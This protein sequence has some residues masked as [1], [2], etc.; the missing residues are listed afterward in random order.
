LARKANYNFAVDKAKTI[1]SSTRLNIIRADD[2][3]ELMAVR[4]FEKYA[5]QNVSFT[6]CVSFAIMRQNGIDDVLGFDKHFEYAGFNL[7]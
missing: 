3:L 4:L 5:D 7:L 2:R 1:Y 6:D